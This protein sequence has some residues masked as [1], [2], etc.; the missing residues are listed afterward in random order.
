MTALVDP[1]IRLQRRHVV[2]DDHASR[3]EAACRNPVIPPIHHGS[4]MSCYR[5]ISEYLNRA[6]P[7][8]PAQ[9][10]RK[11]T[12]SAANSLVAQKRDAL[13]QTSLADVC[14][15]SLTTG[16]TSR[17]DT[18][19][20]TAADKIIHDVIEVVLPSRASSMQSSSSSSH[21]L[22]VAGSQE[23]GDVPPSSS[24]PSL[25]QSS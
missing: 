22:Q 13:M 1:R 3:E 11:R 20:A 6:P 14:T 18:P 12:C 16:M 21:P 17:R 10:G 25:I 19:V 5:S 24:P 8:P 4:L 7:P 23:S 15:E 2:E 9:A